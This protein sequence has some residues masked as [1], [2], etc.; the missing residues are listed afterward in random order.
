MEKRT[1]KS[2]ANAAVFAA[3][4][5]AVG[6]PS[7]AQAK[8]QDAAVSAS[9]SE[10]CVFQAPEFSVTE[11]NGRISGFALEACNSAKS[12]SVTATTRPLRSGETLGIWYD[13]SNQVLE[14]DGW[15]EI[16]N[17]SGPIYRQIPV[18]LNAEQLE[19]PVTVTLSM[20]LI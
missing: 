15:T 17:R 7:L 10:V 18:Q 20:T 19:E 12:Y 5:C 11:A 9:V 6:L 2:L 1:R 3:G 14:N 8:V 4:L 13:N 16:V